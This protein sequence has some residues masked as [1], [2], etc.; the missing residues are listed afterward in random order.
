MRR[1]GRLWFRGMLAGVLLATV[2]LLAVSAHGAWQEPGSRGFWL[3]AA[4]AA[5]LALVAMFAQS[6]LARRLAA[7]NRA[8]RAESLD[9][10]ET[11]ARLVDSRRRLQALLDHMPDGVLSFDVDGRVEWINPAGRL[12]FQRSIA[13]TA[14]RPVAELIPDIEL[15]RLDAAP[16]MAD[17][18]AP[19]HVPRLAMRGMRRDGTQFP[20]EAALVQIEVEQTR[21]GMCVC[22]DISELERIEHMKHE[23][24]S[25]VS[26]ELRTPLTSLRGSLALLADGSIGGLPPDAERLLKLARDNSERL[27]HLVNDILDFE[28]LRAGALRVELEPVDLCAA[29]LHAVE[30]IDGMARQSQVTLRVVAAEPDLPVRADPA[31]LAQ[32]LGNLLSNAIRHSPPHGTVLLTLMRQAE[33]VRLAVLDQGP[34]VPRDFMPRLFEPFAQALGAHHRKPGGT[35]LGLAISRALME[36]MHGGIGLDAPRDAQGASFWIELPLNVARPSTFGDLP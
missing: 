18:L 23:F 29:A 9:L 24:V 21:V 8:L 7:S 15:A 1:L 4:A 3:L 10:A 13:D 36:L 22:R 34:G 30:A 27:V 14:G 5:A 35:G 33:R 26:H 32:V 12:M 6:A 20:L 28:K 17:G 11:Q 2:A 31:R 16:I 19:A 25:M